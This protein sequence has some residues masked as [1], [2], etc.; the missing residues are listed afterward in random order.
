MAYPEQPQPINRVI[1]LRSAAEVRSEPTAPVVG[2]IGAG[3]FTKLQ[4]LPALK[5]T[6]AVIKSIAS[7]GGVTSLHAARKFDAQEATSDY[8]DIL[9]SPEIT[10]V[11]VGTRHDSHPRLV[12]EAL[13][14]GKHVFVEKPL[15][16]DEQGLESVRRAHAANPKL[17]LMVGFNR[18]FAPHTVQAKKLLAGRSQPIA[19]TMMVNAGQLPFDHWQH[20]PLVGG[21]RII[22]EGCHFI[23][24]L[25]HLVGQPI[26]TVQAIS[27]APQ[28]PSRPDDRMT[29]SMTYADGSIGTA[30]YWANGS[31]SFPKE[32]VE[33]FSEN[34]IL[35]IDNWRQLRAFGWPGVPRMKTRQNKGHQAEVAA[36]IERVADGGEPLIPFA[37]LDLVTRASFAAVRSAKE[38]IAIT[39]TA[40]EARAPVNSPAD[41]APA[42]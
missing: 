21:G 28:D 4:L 16:I 15:A 20:D 8:H 35:V 19:V 22:G 7:A 14:A 32:R 34:R 36:F 29:I 33:I 12:V 40:A 1:G 41:E 18:R 26:T 6:S 5:A 9:R 30:H 13:E 37:E 3:N 25:M 42:T 39:L 38:G 2:V 23:D 24:L 10:A 27:L 31:K 17:Q 11:I